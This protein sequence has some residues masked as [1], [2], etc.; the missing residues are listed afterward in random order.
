METNSPITL[1]APKVDKD[2]DVRRIRRAENSTSNVM[3]KSKANYH[4]CFIPKDALYE[5]FSKNGKYLECLFEAFSKKN[6]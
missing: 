4:E 3:S 1:I 5:A 2:Q 6:K